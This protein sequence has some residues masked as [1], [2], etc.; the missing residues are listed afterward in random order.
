MIRRPPR[1]TL[2]PSTTLFRSH[3]IDKSTGADLWSMPL[4]ETTG[5]P[6]TYQT[7]AGRQFV[8]VATGRGTEATLVAF[9]LGG[10]ATPSSTPAATARPAARTSF[11]R[12]GCDA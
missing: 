7:R 4:R 1:S 9:A 11:A 2:F 10:N 3:A 8:L 6:M 5:T 12:A